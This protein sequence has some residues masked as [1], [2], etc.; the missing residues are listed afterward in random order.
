ML[1]HG[2][3]SPDMSSLSASRRVRGPLTLL[4]AIG[5]SSNHGVSPTFWMYPPSTESPLRRPLTGS[6]GTLARWAV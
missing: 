2:A 1:D 5:T 6:Q 4:E 3:H